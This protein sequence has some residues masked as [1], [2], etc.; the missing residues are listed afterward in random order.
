LDIKIIISR[1]YIFFGY[2][3]TK[4]ICLFYIKFDENNIVTKLFPAGNK[5]PKT[6]NKGEIIQDFYNHNREANEPIEP[7]S[8]ISFNKDQQLHP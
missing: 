6:R 8:E 3:K 5:I 4:V 1:E 7:T 2:Y